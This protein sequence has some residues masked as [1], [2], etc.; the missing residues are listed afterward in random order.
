MVRYVVGIEW[1]TLKYIY[2]IKIY[3]KHKMLTL[4]FKRYYKTVCYEDQ[5]VFY[6]VTV[7]YWNIVHI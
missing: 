4:N 1:L 5:L 6:I 7:K 3:V 2:N